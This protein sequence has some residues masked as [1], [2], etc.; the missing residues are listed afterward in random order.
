LAQLTT[1]DFLFIK[2]LVNKQASIV[3]DI[4]K[5]AMVESRL[6]KVCL[7]EQIPTANDLVGRLRGSKFTE[8][9]VKVVESMT[10][11]ETLFFR[12]GNPFE[13]LRKNVI[14]G[15]LAQK[16]QERKLAFWSAASS[17]GQEVYSL[18]MLLQD[19]F[20][21]LAAWNVTTK[22]TDFS[23]EMVNKAKRGVYSEFEINRGL[24]E[25]MRK[26]FFHEEPDG[27]HIQD[28]LRSQIDF[29][30]L[31]LAG[32]WSFPA[33]FDVILLRN[34]LIYFDTRTRLEILA[35][36]HMHLQPDGWLILGTGEAPPAGGPAF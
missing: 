28:K 18:K 15:L 3:L 7:R 6:A 17:T 14:P 25:A 31:N 16:A 19:A 10:T 24:P 36:M 13:A 29:H 21:E 23:E 33:R 12:D 8:L 27:F 30:T 20:P 4:E 2:E 1:A 22:A 11:N 9:H 5:I 32:A 34:V 35:K 26:K